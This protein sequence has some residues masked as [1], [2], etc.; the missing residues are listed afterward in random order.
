VRRGV[1]HNARVLYGTLIAES[2]RLDAPLEAMG[3][4]MQRIIRRAADDPP[5]WTFIEFE[6]DDAHAETLATALTG[7]LEA[8]HGWY[9]DF[10]TPAETFVVFA[11]KVF[12]YPRGD[13]TSRAEAENYARSVGVPDSQLDWPE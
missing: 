8:E 11:G 9:C 13:A 4:R 12:R 1:C 6:A 2:L 3:L 5:I 7:T 10:R